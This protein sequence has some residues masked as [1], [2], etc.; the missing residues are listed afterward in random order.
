LHV[1][2]FAVEVVG[3]GM[4]FVGDAGSLLDRQQKLAAARIDAC[5]W[6]V[7]RCRQATPRGLGA[8]VTRRTSWGVPWPE[9]VGPW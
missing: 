5:L 1:H 2:A 9:P 4:A 3:S 7:G 8:W 6:L